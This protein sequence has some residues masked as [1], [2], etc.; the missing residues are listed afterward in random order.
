MHP[1]NREL[2]FLVALG[3][4]PLACTDKG[5]DDTVSS[6]TDGTTG[7][8]TGGTSDSASSTSGTVPTTS[9]ATGDDGSTSAATQDPSNPTNAS[10][11][12]LSASAS[13][14]DSDSDSDTDS[15]TF[16]PPR[17]TD[18]TCIAYAEKI[19]ECFPQ[20]EYY[21]PYIGDGCEY[22]KNFGL[23]NDGQACH[24]AMDALFVCLSELPCEELTSEEA[25]SEEFAAA[26]ELCPT[27]FSEEPDPSES[28]GDPSDTEGEDTGDT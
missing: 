24:D 18:P 6:T 26:E 16:D 20:Y 21:R 13:D 9:G 4:L 15:D 11:A 8:T 27:V 14:S 7:G 23:E 12:F 17:P 19:V 2:A 5:S 10:Q 25:C 3:S 1:H 22:Y 28:S